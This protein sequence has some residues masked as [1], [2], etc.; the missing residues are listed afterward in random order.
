LRE[1]QFLLREEQFLMRRPFAQLEEGRQAGHET[2]GG[3]DRGS[4]PPTKL[5]LSCI[6]EP[7]GAQWQAFSLEFGLAAQADTMQD[8]KHR[9]DSM[10]RAY[11]SDALVGEDREH[12]HELLTR[13]A[14]WQSIFVIILAVFFLWSGRS[15][16]TLTTM[17]R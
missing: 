8:A 6:V 10:I 15:R 16:I 4:S 3:A 17:I 1:E 13:R 9:L 5:G 14:T 7:K 11:V 2:Q 12:A